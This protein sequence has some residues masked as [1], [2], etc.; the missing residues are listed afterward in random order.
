M[1]VPPRYP[2]VVP[3]AL[4]MV[5]CLSFG[6][7]ALSAQEAPR[8]KAAQKF[9]AERK[10]VLPQPDG[11]LLC[12]AEEFTL[13]D[14]K[15]W[16]AR[17]YG[18]NYY[19]ATFSNS[20]L[21]R[22]AFLGAPENGPRSEA[23]TALAVP[24]SGRYQVLVRYEAA[25]RFETQFGVRIEQNG[26][27]VFERLYGA[28]KNV[29]VWAF[30]ERLKTE[31]GW[32][33][34]ACEN[35][36][37]EGHDAFAELQP[38]TATLTLVADAQ[39]E[40]A[41]RRN[42][43]L[44]LLT[45][46]A[47]QVAERIQKDDH[48]PLDGMLTQSGD[49]WVRV[50]NKGS[51]PLTFQSG[52]AANRGPKRGANWR[53]HSP[54]WVHNRRWPLPSVE[55][56]PGAS[57]E[58][59]EVGG[60]MDTLA[61]G[62]WTWTG[63]GP[64]EAE[65]GLRLPDGKI[66]RI[67]LFEGEGDLHLAADCDTR[68]MKRL[69]RREDVLPEL[70]ALLEKERLQGKAPVRT[71]VYAHCFEPIP[72]AAAHNAALEKFRALYG[73]TEAKADGGSKR[74]Y[75]DV[76][77]VPT[78]KL[79]EHCRT[80]LGVP[81]G[82]VAVVSLGDEIGLPVPA[83][84]ADKEAFA[85]WLRTQGQDPALVGPY[86]ATPG[87]RE[88]NPARFYWSAR[89]THAFGIAK[90]KE[91]TDI[92]RR[93]LPNAGIGANYSPHYPQHHLYLGEVH[94][95][96]HI[97]REGGMTMPWSEDY[98]WQVP[99]LSPQINALNID[100][101]RAGIRH[102]P[103]A[104]IHFYVMP[105]MPNNTPAMW[106]RLFY[107]ALAHGT[108]IFNLFEFRTVHGAYT[109]NHVDEPEM[110]VAVLKG[111]RELGSM[112]DAVQEAR[113]APAQTGLWM[114]E[115]ADIWGDSKGSFGAAK[116]ALYLAVRHHQVPL[117]L[118]LE[119]DAADGTL[120]QYKVLFLADRHVSRAASARIADWVRKGGRLFAT[121][122]AGMKDELDQPNTVLRALLGAAENRLEAPEDR[123]VLWIKQDLPFAEALTTAG[124][125]PVYGVRSHFTAADGVETVLRFADGTPAVVRSAAGKG[126]A[127]YC[128]FLPG[129]SYYSGA[130][131]KR[132]V[133]RGATD[134]AFIH[135]LPTAYQPKAAELLWEPLQKVARPVVCDA[136]LVESTVLA[137][138]KGSVVPLIN[139]SR[140]PRKG[141]RVRIEGGASKAALA[142]GAAVRLEKEGAA[143][144]CVLDLDV[145][146][147]LLLT[148]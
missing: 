67:G 60:T 91:R 110:Y 8:P 13:K 58:W 101:F 23:S 78:D 48:L 17:D 102:T 10:A 34:G 53:E 37:W 139:W 136:P 82:D 40:P 109:E 116:R 113:V 79:A 106:R 46:D 62:Q 128:G 76:R 69:R 125:L 7:A 137:H 84:A 63:N 92:L 42:V 104:R 38:G 43:D 121:A 93:E 111:L 61:H 3:F 80:R 50:K 55:V 6:V 134:D 41:A 135:F 148:P 129:L 28:R 74:G 77:S 133:D 119:P 100:L 142:S 5:S 87:L 2:R 140:T 96:A 115:T 24:A 89:Y 70:M 141:L 18:E 143:A 120:N 36:V 132:P 126:E 27:T 57:S 54:Y 122:G 130:I 97:F 56:A 12:E 14:A 31:V 131:P 66:E 144:V 71:P 107:G 94:K 30:K 59:V 117:D 72:G 45:T 118:L 29:K 21:S 123:Q 22:Q 83:S 4:A 16:K 33:W 73:I 15:G 85:G 49:V 39:P 112:E 35:M 88:S 95:W 11:L 26:R 105:H 98:I 52:L 114:G 108:K 124:E 81:P 138:S 68:Y 75:V 47:A 86:D 20:F 1:S 25:Y 99:V 32:S 64:Y 9:G 19:A 90:L 146:D 51:A 147:A 127:T 65:F 103:E 44:V 145:A